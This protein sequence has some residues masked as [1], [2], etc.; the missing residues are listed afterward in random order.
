MDA[1]PAALVT[2]QQQLAD[3]SESV[4]LTHANF[5]ELTIAVDKYQVS[6]LDGVLFDL[7]LSSL[8]LEAGG[9]GFSF[10]RDEPLDM[11]RDPRQVVMA[12]DLLNTTPERDLAEIFWSLGEERQAKRIAKAIMQSRPLFSTNQ[13]VRVIEGV[14]PRRGRRIH[15][16]TKVFQALR[17]AVNSD[18]QNLEA[19]LEQVVPL[20]ALGGRM[21]IVSYQSLEDRI[22]KQF[23]RREAQ[24]CVCPREVP[25]CQCEHKATIRLITRKAIT[26]SVQE[27]SANPRSR[28]ARLRVGE[29]I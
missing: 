27:V 28:S 13:L 3:Y 8:Q 7:G 4:T 25:L 1:D 26:P 2:A 6:P 17:L 12:T 19:S 23:L 29:R 18:L 15:P 9:R 24:D 20:L 10:Q 21:A 5:S 16:A 22:V 14:A 11:R